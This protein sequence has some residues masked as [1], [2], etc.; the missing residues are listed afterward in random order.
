MR[1]GAGW[2]PEICTLCLASTPALIGNHE[3]LTSVDG[4]PPQARSVRPLVTLASIIILR[5]R[6]IAVKQLSTISSRRIRL[7]SSTGKAEARFAIDIFAMAADLACHL[8]TNASERRMAISVMKGAA[9]VMVRGIGHAPLCS[10][11]IASS[12]AHATVNNHENRKPAS[13]IRSCRPWRRQYAGPYSSG[14]KDTGVDK[15]LRASLQDIA[16]ILNDDFREQQCR[17]R[18]D[19]YSSPMS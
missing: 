12:S 6:R 1:S 9:A 3:N 18:C 11:A 2:R 7:L 15:H 13:A 5:L 19:A 8:M 14:Y 4:P 16:T 17:R 10:P